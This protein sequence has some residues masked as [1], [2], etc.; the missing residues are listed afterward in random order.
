MRQKALE[1]KNRLN[2][3][4]LQIK[5]SKREHEQSV[6][7]IYSQEPAKPKNE[8]P[9]KQSQAESSAPNQYDTNLYDQKSV[10]QV[11]D[12]KLNLAKTTEELIQQYKDTLEQDIIEGKATYKLFETYEERIMRIEAKW[13]R[14]QIMEF[15]DEEGKSQK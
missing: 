8:A 13:L 3:L 2:D 9:Q 6:K 12:E 11:E 14:S 1:Y 10:K 15:E 4:E 7:K 5:Q